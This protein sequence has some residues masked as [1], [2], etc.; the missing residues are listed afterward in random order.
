MGPQELPGSESPRSQD[1]GT[2]WN[3]RAA[4]TQHG[5]DPPPQVTGRTKQART[6]VVLAQQ[7]A[8]G[9]LS[10]TMMSIVAAIHPNT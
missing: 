9:K 1:R 3:L 2:A 10:A 7:R 4:P 6:G 5:S 8:H